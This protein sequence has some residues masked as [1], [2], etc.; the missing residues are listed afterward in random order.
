MGIGGASPNVEV[1]S[2]VSLKL[3]STFCDGR[4]IET[5]AL[6]VPRVVRDLPTVHVPIDRRWS[7]LRDLQLADPDFNIPSRVDVLLGVDIFTKVVLDGRRKGDEGTPVAMETLFGWVLCGNVESSTP[8]AF[9]VTVCHTL[10]DTNNDFANSGRLKN[11]PLVYCPTCLKMNVLLFNSSKP[12]TLVR[13][14][15]DLWSPYQG[16]RVI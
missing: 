2:V 1:D 16:H 8:C 13:R 15:V 9:T 14:M 7:H 3:C 6:V 10:V 12:N 4:M 5:T 11:H